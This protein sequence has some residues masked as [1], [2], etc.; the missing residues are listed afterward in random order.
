MIVR[1][2]PKPT[3]QA[4]LSALR[5]AN[6]TVT[7]KAGIYSAETADSKLVFRAMPGQR[8]YLVRM[9]PDLFE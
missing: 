7:K 1:R 5:A 9:V 2:I 4:M 8:D 3:V 6:M